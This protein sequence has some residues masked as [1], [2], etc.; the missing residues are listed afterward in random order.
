MAGA[1]GIDW[2]KEEWRQ[3]WRNVPAEYPR[4][5]PIF[6]LPGFLSR[7]FSCLEVPIPPA[8]PDDLVPVPVH[9]EPFPAPGIVHLIILRTLEADVVRLRRAHL[10]PSYLIFLAVYVPL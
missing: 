7:I 4:L 2:L 5:L 8:L 6:L 3:E 1:G 9:P 10:R